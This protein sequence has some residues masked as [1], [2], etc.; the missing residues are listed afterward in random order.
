MDHW[1]KIV[2]LYSLGVAV[3]AA[4][5][6]LPSQGILT[7]IGLGLFGYGVYE[8]FQIG[9]MVG[10]I[11]VAVL[12]VALPAAFILGVRV[13]HRT[14]IGRRIS[15]P[16]PTLT[17]EDRLPVSDL[18]KLLGTSGRAVTI[19]RP[20]GTCEFNGRRV[21]CKAESGLIEAGTEVQ[22]VRLSDRTVVVRPLP[23]V[24]STSASS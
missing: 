17:A 8:A 10:V 20:V 21:E 2:I 12:T 24:E 15:P 4:D 16:N 18:Q 23:T 14:P 22:A 13:W 1:V 5:L 19:L 11:H 7:A 3:L 9:T 6:F